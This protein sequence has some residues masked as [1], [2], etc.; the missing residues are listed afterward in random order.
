MQT[1]RANRNPFVSSSK[2]Y[3]HV[4][5]DSAMIVSDRTLF[6]V[7]NLKQHSCLLFVF[8]HP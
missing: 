2:G 8:F 7:D 5:Q 1:Q 4:L 6:V 3:V